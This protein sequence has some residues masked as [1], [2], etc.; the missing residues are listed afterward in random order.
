MSET[1]D[2]VAIEDP[3]GSAEVAILFEDAIFRV[4]DADGWTNALQEAI[5]ALVHFAFEDSKILALIMDKAEDS[6]SMYAH[7]SYMMV[8]GLV[9]QKLQK[10]QT[11]KDLIFIVD[12]SDEW[13]KALQEAVSA[14]IYLAFEDSEVL[15]LVT[16]KTRL[17]L[18]MYAHLSYMII[19]RLVQEEKAQAAK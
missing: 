17:H 6:L 13:S 12:H 3:V 14:L 19:I 16:E 15:A 1:L 5:S 11:A 9:E 2:E 10:L 8:V 4:D 7:M 18:R